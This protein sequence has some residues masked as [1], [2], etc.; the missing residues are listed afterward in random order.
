MDAFIGLG[1][2][3]YV[4]NQYAPLLKL[5]HL[6]GAEKLLKYVPFHNIFVFP[7]FLSHYLKGYVHKFN[8]SVLAFI[9]LI[10][11][12]VQDS[13]VDYDLMA[14]MV[15]HEPG[16]TSAM[17]MRHWFQAMSTDTFKMFDYGEEGN[18]EHYG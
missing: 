7:G 15:R 8:H 17:N 6:V 10:T 18:K 16:G 2:V 9:E 5:A 4:D 11:G 13:N 12:P 14:S 3:L 1:P